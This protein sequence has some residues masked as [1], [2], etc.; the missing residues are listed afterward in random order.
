MSMHKLDIYD[1]GRLRTLESWRLYALFCMRSQTEAVV[2][3]G[4]SSI[5]YQRLLSLKAGMPYP[6]GVCLHASIGDRGQARRFEAALHRA[7]DYRNTR[8][9]WFEFN[10]ADPVDKF[11]F[12][13]TVNAVFR[14]YFVGDLKWE[15]ITPEQLAEY[16]NLM[17][18]EAKE[19]KARKR[20]RPFY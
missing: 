1:A 12:H 6:M 18:Q 14:S 19:K 10:L 5:V 16:A 15:K 2:K 4:I 11:A 8:G 17:Q 3:I 13:N 20:S 7:F 9:E